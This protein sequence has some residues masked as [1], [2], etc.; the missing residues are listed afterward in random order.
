ME[1]DNLKALEQRAQS[2]LGAAIDRMQGYKYF[3]RVVLVI[4]VLAVVGVAAIVL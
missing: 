3:G 4:V 1:T 2:R